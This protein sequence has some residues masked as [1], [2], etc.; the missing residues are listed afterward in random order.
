MT[1]DRH[2]SLGHALRHAFTSCSPAECN[3]NT[4]VRVC[5]H[6]NVQS[7]DGR[8]TQLGVQVQVEAPTFL[9]ICNFSY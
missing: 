4:C 6:S 8:V 9:H 3:G 7:A 1:R 2:H 5:G